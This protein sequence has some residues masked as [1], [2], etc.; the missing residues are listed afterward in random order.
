MLVG[1][2]DDHRALASSSVGTL[3]F[4]WRKFQHFVVIELLLEVFAVSEK[5]EELEGRF[6]RMLHAVP[7][8]FIEEQFQKVVRTGTA[9]FDLDEVGGREDRTEE[10]EVEDVGAVV[11]GGHHADRHA[12]SRLAGLVG[13]NEVAGAEQI[14]V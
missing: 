8:A 14:V 1:S 9:P 11:A 10:A 4:G 5:V 13:R 12:H 7:S 3:S 2:A 6:R